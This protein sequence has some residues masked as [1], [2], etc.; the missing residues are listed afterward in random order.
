MKTTSL[1]QASFFA[2]AIGAPLVGGA[3]LI[4]LAYSPL[5]L[6]L[7]AYLYRTSSPNYLAFCIWLW[8]LTPLVRR[9]VDYNT[10][11]HAQSLVMLAPFIASLVSGASLR[12]VVGRHLPI[13]LVPFLGIGLILLW[14]YVVGLFGA[15]LFAATY[16]ALTWVSPLFL[17]IH[18]MVERESIG[19]NTDQVIRAFQSAALILAAYGLYQFFFFPEWDRFWVANAE[20]G[21]IGFAEVASLR[22][23]STMNSPGVFALFLAAG[24]IVSLPKKGVWPKLIIVVGITA[25][26]LSL[27]RSAWACFVM[28]FLFML[29]VMPG[30]ERVRYFFGA[31]MIALVGVPFLF[32]EPIAGQIEA[33]LQT[34][35]NLED[36]VSFQARSNLYDE[37][38]ARALESLVGNGIGSTGTASRLSDSQQLESVDSGLVD[39]AFTFGILSVLIFTLLAWI[40]VLAIRSYRLG[41]A[42]QSAIAITLAMTVQL[43]FANIL[44]APTGVIFFIFSALAVAQPK[45]LYT[46]PPSSHT[47]SAS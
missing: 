22:I 38:S 29:A 5:A 30:R 23:F 33:R 24:M 21:A 39:L 11:Y 44:Y 28:G 14:A 15:G 3:G 1:A 16:A 37:F 9:L 34:L 31:I 45:V 42:A 4:N 8:V 18:I 36:D 13:Y 2:L 12:H 25:L 40:C 20:M 35:T 6:L 27:V 43:A 26:M 46:S 32:V 10:I 17:A 19:E 41:I 47:S 7:A